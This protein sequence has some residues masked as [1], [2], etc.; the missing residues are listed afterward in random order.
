MELTWDL[1]FGQKVIA[2]HIKAHDVNQEKQSTFLALDQE[3]GSQDFPRKG[4]QECSL[5]F[6]DN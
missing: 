1:Y 4:G 5:L 3:M 2:P 6:A